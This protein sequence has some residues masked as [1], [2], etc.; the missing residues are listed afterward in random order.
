[1]FLI[2]SPGPV[3][4]QIHTQDMYNLN[5]GSSSYAWRPWIRLKL[6]SDNINMKGRLILKVASH[7]RSTHGQI[8]TYRHWCEYWKWFLCNYSLYKNDVDISNSANDLCVPPSQR[9]R[10]HRRICWSR[11]NGYVAR[12]VSL[13]VLHGMGERVATHGSNARRV[14]RGKI[15][16]HAASHVTSHNWCP[17]LYCL[18]CR[19]LFTF[20]L[21]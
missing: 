16:A 12:V 2:Q 3:C 20:A 17:F 19:S 8:K 7:W 6:D 18:A 13:C 11:V 10:H 21:V 9:P 14:A 1:L 15:K 4:L 5:F